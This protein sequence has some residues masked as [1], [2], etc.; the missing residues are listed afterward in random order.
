MLE[1]LRYISSKLKTLDEA[2]LYCSK[3]ELDYQ[4]YL[5]TMHIEAKKAA[6]DAIRNKKY[7]PL[8]P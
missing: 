2:K 8:N 6:D 3:R 5:E 7:L 1:S 4:E